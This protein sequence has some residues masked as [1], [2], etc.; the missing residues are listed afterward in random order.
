MNSTDSFRRD[1][2]LLEEILHQVVS[3]D[4]GAEF[5]DLIA[6]IRR[7]SHDRRANVP[8]SEALLSEKIESLS[9]DQIRVVTRFQ[10]LF[11]DLVNIAEDRQRIRVLRKRE[12]LTHP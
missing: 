7:L 4:H 8:G 3:E 10:S 5:L 6:Q 2:N 12:Q 11:F 1:L 9:E